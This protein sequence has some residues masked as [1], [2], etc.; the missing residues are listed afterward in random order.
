MFRFAVPT[1]FA[2]ILTAVS[3]RVH[4]DVWKWMDPQGHVQYSDRWVPGA[5]LIKSDRTREHPEGLS[6]PE[7]QKSLAA[8]NERANAQLSEQSA[9]AAVHQDVATVRTEQ[10]KQAK[11]RYQ[12]MIEARRIFS[13]GKDGERQYLTDEEADKQRLQARLDMQQVCGSSNAK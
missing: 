3:A 6:S 12:K 10:C 2:L 5:E 13:T 7:A 9:A 8:L 1:A 11:E 4:A